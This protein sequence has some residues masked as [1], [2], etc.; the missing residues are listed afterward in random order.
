[1]R[2]KRQDTR[3]IHYLSLLTGTPLLSFSLKFERDS[4]DNDAE[5][6]EYNRNNHDEYD[7]ES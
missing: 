1:M 2:K 7:S 3:E 5:R 6:W 4:N